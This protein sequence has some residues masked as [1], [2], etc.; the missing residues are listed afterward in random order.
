MRLHEIKRLYTAK[1]AID[2]VTTQTLEWEQLL[3]SYTS[4]ST[5]TSTICKELQN[6]NTLRW[7]E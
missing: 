7:F 4:N 2:Q 5:L 1:K 6:L 3:G